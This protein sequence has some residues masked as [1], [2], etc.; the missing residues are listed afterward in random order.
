MKQL[1]ISIVTV[2]LL[3]MGSC[4]M[5][6]NTLP[7]M[8]QSEPNPF[9]IKLYV[10]PPMSLLMTNLKSDTYSNEEKGSLGFNIG[11]DFMYYYLTKGKF[12]ASISLG[13]GYT[14]YRSSRSLS[15]EQSIWTTDVDGDDVF[16][17]ETVDNMYELQNFSYLDIPL[18]FGFEYT[19]SQELEA[20]VSVGCT[21]GFNLKGKYSNQATITRNGYYPDFNALIY[22]VDV[23]GSPYFY[24]TNKKM[25]TD[26]IISIKKNISFESALGLKLKLNPKIS[27]LA[28][29]KY[30]F[31]FSD[32]IN[33]HDSF[34]VKHNQAYH[35]SLNSLAGRGDKIKTSSIG[36]E[37]GVQLNIWK[38][39]K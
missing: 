34:I 2:L 11:A 10:S 30:M 28:G 32:V 6:Q 25:T 29:V 21:Y 38:L 1:K 12:R 26:D 24:P 22:D 36:L 37:L 33:E 13:I 17:T 19:L 39:L 15:F 27:I 5:A 23:E 31:G 35:Y 9:A 16:I 4:V 18:K 8:R 14:N 7:D 20:Y 3:I